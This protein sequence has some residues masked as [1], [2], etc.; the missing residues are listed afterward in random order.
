[1]KQWSLYQHKIFQFVESES[2]NAIIEAVAGSGKSTTIIECLSRIP[3]D[4]Q[5]IFLAF[6]KTIADELKAKGVNARTFHSLTYMPVIKNKRATAVDQDKLRKIIQNELRGNESYIYGSFV[7]KLVSLGRQTGIGCLLP[8]TQNEWFK[9]VYQYDLQLD[10]EEADYDT[11]VELASKVLK[12]SNASQ[13]VDFDDLLYLSVKD[14][15]VLPKFDFVF[16]DEAQDT[17]A[18]QRAILRKIMKPTSRIVAVGD[19]SQA[20]YGFRGADSDSMNLIATEFNCIKLPLTVTY[21]CPTSVV[22]YAKRYV[23]EIES[24]PNAELGKVTHLNKAWTHE[25]FAAQDL[26]VCRTTKPLIKLAFKLIR[27]KVPCYMLGKE[28]GQGLKVL[29]N[30]RRAKTIEQLEKKLDIWAD[31]E[32]EKAIA[33]QQEATAEAIRDK[34]ASIY[35]IIESLP[36]KDRTV[37]GLLSTIDFLFSDKSNAT[38]LSTIHKAKGLESNRVFWLNSSQCPSKWAKLDWQIK[39]EYNLCYVAITRAKQ[40]LFLI[41]E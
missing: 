40:E 27:E 20:I 5:S 3:K 19:S 24:A 1:M 7:A 26:V 37:D 34:V 35:A 29:I 28:I 31:R 36:D 13:M 23:T 22:D 25:H 14:G 39:Q 12:L 8:D 41:E 11:A 32:C 16:V 38:V 6:N 15:L 2:G 4:K 30:S 17:N 21:R 18:I 10:H 9:I 33:K